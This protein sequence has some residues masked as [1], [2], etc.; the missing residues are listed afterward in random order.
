MANWRVNINISFEITSD[1][2][3]EW[4][5]FLANRNGPKADLLTERVFLDSFIGRD[6]IDSILQFDLLRRALDV[7]S[8]WTIN[9]TN[10]KSGT[11]GELVLPNEFRSNAV[12]L[13][14]ADVGRVIRV[15]PGQSPPATRGHYLITARNGPNS[16]DVDG[17]LPVAA[18][19]LNFEI[20]DNDAEFLATLLS[21]A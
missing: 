18:T 19:G 17:V 20:N 16:V 5:F 8:Q 13:A 6:R 1:E 14:V 11:D 21:T 3:D 7:H 10:R 9:G 15:N 4:E 12:T 2:I